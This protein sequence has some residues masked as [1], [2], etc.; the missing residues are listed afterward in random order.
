MNDFILSKDADKLL[1]T[2]YKEYLDR[3]NNNMSKSE[4]SNFELIEL[5]KLIP[6]SNKDDISNDLHELSKNKLIKLYLYEDF[7]L[8][9]NGIVYMENRFFNK[10]DK[11]VD[12]IDKLKPF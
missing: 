10:I 9:S 6:S 1:C 5:L 8:L 2:I 3:I 11:L 12:Y 7:C 4:A